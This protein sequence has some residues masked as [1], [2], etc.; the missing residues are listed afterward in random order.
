MAIIKLLKAQT[1]FKQ[2]DQLQPQLKK[3]ATNSPVLCK[4]NPAETILIVYNMSGKG[5]AIV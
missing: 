4:L 2:E 5:S 3:T 1:S